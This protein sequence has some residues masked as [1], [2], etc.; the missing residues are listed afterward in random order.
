LRILPVVLYAPTWASLAPHSD[1]SPPSDPLLFAR[2]LAALARRY[3]SAGTFWTE[4]PGLAPVPVR[5]WQVWNEPNIGHYWPQPFARGYVQLLKSAHAALAQADPRAR[6]V[7]S[8]LTNDSWNALVDIYKAGGKPYFDAVALHPY[9]SRVRGLVKILAFVRYGMRRFHDGLK[10]IVVTELSWPSAAGRVK[11]IGFNEVTE[12]QQAR[13]VTASYQLLAKYRR[14]FRIE[15]AYWYTWL[16][17]DRGP[18]YFNYA[19]LRK[20][21]PGGPATKP[22]FRAF[23]RVVRQIE[24]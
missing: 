6:L 13:R 11:H 18:Y 9:T 17:I 20:M 24:R 7:L 21:T 14:H 15:A 1:A 3:G 4:N 16:S 5:D 10:P 8:G 23:K 2:Y 12:R 22:A 19:G